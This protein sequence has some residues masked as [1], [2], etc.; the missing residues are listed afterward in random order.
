M[1]TSREDLR[2]M[3]R[4]FNGLRGSASSQSIIGTVEYISTFEIPR[5]RNT[6]ADVE[7][8]MVSQSLFLNLFPV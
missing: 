8:W 3:Q 7:T 6:E 1:A 4:Q 2:S 5:R